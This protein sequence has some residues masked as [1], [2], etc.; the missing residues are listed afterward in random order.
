MLLSA[1][2]HRC[3]FSFCSHT[4]R[5]LTSNQILWQNRFRNDIRND[6]L[7]S[8][9]GT[10]FRIFEP[11]PF[12]PGWYSHKFHG[13]GLRYEVALCIRSGDIVWVSGPFPCGEWSDLKIFDNELSHYL[14]P[15][16]R[17]EADKG[18]RHRYPQKVKTHN[19]NERLGKKWMRKEVLARHEHV[20]G[21]F[22]KFAILRE[23]F[24]HTSDLMGQHGMAFRAVAVITQLSFSHG[25]PLYSVYY[26]DE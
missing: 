21:R 2:A 15:G 11:K 4:T 17:V 24:R 19:P 22:K 23:R 25:E 10:D 26:V 13:P 20:N 7:V 8:V 9:D 6:C 16:E 12:H 3:C 14:S 5:H 18:Y 1:S